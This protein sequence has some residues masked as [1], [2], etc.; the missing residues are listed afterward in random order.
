MSNS[1]HRLKK[2]VQTM[3]SDKPKKYLPVFQ[4]W[5]D[6]EVYHVGSRGSDQ[7]M[8]W[9]EIDNQYKDWVIFKV[10]YTDDWRGSKHDT[11]QDTI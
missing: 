1:E 6:P 7:T 2:L 5:D 11:D 4:D 8:T 9:P 10:T 3:Q